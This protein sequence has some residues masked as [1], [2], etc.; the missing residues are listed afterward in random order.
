MWTSKSVAFALGAVA[1]SAVSLAD[2]AVPTTQVFVVSAQIVAGCG[3]VGGSGSSGLNFGALDFGAH[4]AI[5]TG[6]VSAATNGSA[7]QIQCSPG[8]TLKMTVDGGIQPS[9]GNTQRNLKGPSGAQV[10]YRLYADVAQTQAIG[11]GQTISIPV[12]G[13]TS[14]PIYG[15]L[16]LPGGVAP[17]GAYTD[18]AQVT[19]SY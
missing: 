17:V 10:A 9:A 19:L 16:T 12:S 18:V 7:L 2:T 14:L 5:A 3:V 15:A 8:S 4:P 13:T 1:L 11:I 6:N